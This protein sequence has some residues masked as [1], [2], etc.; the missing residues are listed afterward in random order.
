MA[1]KPHRA[2][3]ASRSRPRKFSGCCDACGK[4][5]CSCRVYQYV[6][7][8]NA[9]ISANSPFLCRECYEKRYRVKIPTEIDAYKARLLSSLDYLVSQTENSDKR[10]FIVRLMRLIQ[11]TD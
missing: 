1:Y 5:L 9:A 2:I 4:T 3:R 8:S 11:A 10:E 6:D 7:E